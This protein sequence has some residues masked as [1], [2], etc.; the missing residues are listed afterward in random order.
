MEE[1]SLVASAHPKPR[2]AHDPDGPWPHVQV[3]HRPEQVRRHVSASDLRDLLGQLLA[4]GLV[5]DVVDGHALE[6][7]ALNFGVEGREQLV[8]RALRAGAT[9]LGAGVRDREDRAGPNRC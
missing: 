7:V 1:Q 9:D 5:R 2:L 6:A 8:E 3:G 4:G